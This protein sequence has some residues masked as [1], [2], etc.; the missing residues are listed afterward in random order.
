MIN[1]KETGETLAFYRL[2]GEK[3][4]FMNEFNWGGGDGKG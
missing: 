4:F 2:W 3:K 1:E